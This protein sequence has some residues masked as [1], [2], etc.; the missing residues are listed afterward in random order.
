V[1]IVVVQMEHGESEESPAD[2]EEIR[3]D[4]LIGEQTRT[5]PQA[6][7]GPDLAGLAC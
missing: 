2:Y 7:A 1:W 4:C 3:R 5:H 6:V